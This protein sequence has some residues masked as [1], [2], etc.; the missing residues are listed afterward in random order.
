M[1][2]Q[3]S[4]PFLILALPRSRTAWLSR[5]LSYGPWVCSHEESRHLRALEDVKSWF[6]QEYVGSVET[7]VAPWWRLVPE[8]TRV[9][10]VRRPVADVLT[11]LARLGIG[12]DVIARRMTR[13]DAKLSQVARRW[14]GAW[15]VPYADLASEATCAAVFERLLGLPHD[16]EWWRMWA[17]VNVQVNF[18]GLVR[19]VQAYGPQID[20]FAALATGAVR[21]QLAMR[22]VPARDGLV[23]A[24]EP[25]A[26]FTRDGRDLFREHSAA[27]G[28]PGSS[29]EGKNL[30]F[31]GEIEAV[32]RLQIVTARS[33][34]RMFGYLMTELTPSREAPGR[35]AAVETAFF[36]SGS[37]PGLG[38]K[39]QRE[40]LRRL[41]A[42]GVGEVW[43]RAGPRGDG[44]RTGAMFRRLGAT[45]DGQ[46]YRLSLT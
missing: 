32:G 17:D 5:W 44:P 40:S 4:S 35:V 2:N 33:N 14:P 7:V 20:R 30:P 1:T 19:Y 13:L 10:V 8:G 22:P 39:L 45:P 25:L 41:A 42:R 18:P 23:L 24:E 21:Q 31:L 11:S 43:F 26:A 27:V 28:E 3:T 9:V 29:W 12:G 15:E 16:P 37:W 6:A 34:G 46:L 38:M 36:A